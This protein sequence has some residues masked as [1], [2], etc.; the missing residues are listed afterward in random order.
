MQQTGVWYDLRRNKLIDQMNTFLDSATAI[1]AP[2]R[3]ASVN[4]R[5][6]TLTYDV[7][8]VEAE[9]MSTMLA[10]PV[11]VKQCG[12]AAVAHLANPLDRTLPSNAFCTQNNS[13]TLEWQRLSNV[14]I[15]S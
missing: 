2:A 14:V 1:D 11:N 7:V 10:R 12:T 4:G 6:R 13:L 3:L 8:A 9:D 15:T 5:T